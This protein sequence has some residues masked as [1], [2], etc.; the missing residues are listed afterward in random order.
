MLQISLLCFRSHFSLTLRERLVHRQDR[1]NIDDPLRVT[2]FEHTGHMVG[3]RPRIKAALIDGTYV[4]FFWPTASEHDTCVLFD[5]DVLADAVAMVRSCGEA[6]AERGK[7][8]GCGHQHVGKCLHRTS[9]DR[10]FVERCGCTVG[11]WPASL[12]ERDSYT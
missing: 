4:V 11:G 3:S 5:N 8:A 9:Y 2:R 10:G 12:P 7:C 6:I 1:M